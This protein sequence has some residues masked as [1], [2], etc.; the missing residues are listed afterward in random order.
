MSGLRR[1][2]PR[3][4]SIIHRAAAASAPVFNSPDDHI[5][6]PPKRDGRADGWG[7][8]KR[9]EGDGERKE[10]KGWKEGAVEDVISN[11]WV[12]SSFTASAADSYWLIPI[13]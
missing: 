9:G 3:F 8:G 7:G 4:P 1:V 2:T 6:P 12:L 13:G 11:V 10:V 5:I